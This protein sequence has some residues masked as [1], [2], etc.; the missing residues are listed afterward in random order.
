MYLHQNQVEGTLG[1]LVTPCQGVSNNRQGV[2]GAQRA[3]QARRP[4]LSALQSWRSSLSARILRTRSPLVTVT[5]VPCSKARI[6][7][8]TMVAVSWQSA[9]R[10]AGGGRRATC[11]LPQAAKHISRDR[12]SSPPRVLGEGFLGFDTVLHFLG[13]GGPLNSC[14]GAK[15]GPVSAS[16]AF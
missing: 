16:S 1:Y 13:H 14:C 8:S 15:R 10:A 5:A 3:L 7:A 9:V 4:A 2:I 12:L 6:A 11:L